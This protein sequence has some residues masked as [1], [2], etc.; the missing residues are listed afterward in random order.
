MTHGITGTL[1]Y[2]APE[3]AKG[4]DVDQRADG[5]AVGLIIYDLLVGRQRGKRTDGPVTELQARMEHA[6]PPVRSLVADI[7][8]PLDHL[9]SRCLE[10]D[11][12]KRFQ[13]TAELQAALNRLDEKGEL[14]PIKRVVRLPAVVAVVALLLA[15]SVAIWWYQS[16]RIPP[17]PHEPGIGGDR[18]LPEW[19]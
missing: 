8:E 3:Q 15:M 17:A 12:D 10:P 4:L 13:T 14:I 19:H 18:G 5:Y 7:P 1:E 6:P 9:I 11:P 2:M 16:S